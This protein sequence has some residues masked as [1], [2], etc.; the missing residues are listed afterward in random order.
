MSQKKY[1]KAQLNLLYCR[2]DFLE[3]TFITKVL[4]LV[5][6]KNNFELMGRVLEKDM[7]IRLNRGCLL[8]FTLKYVVPNFPNIPD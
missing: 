1:D 7:K 8:R 6:T 5:L 3:K 2:F 4:G